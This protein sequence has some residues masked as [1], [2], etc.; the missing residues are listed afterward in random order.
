VE[1]AAVTVTPTVP[2]AAFNAKLPAYCTTILFVPTS[3]REALIVM[4]AE[5]VE[6]VPPRE[7][8]PICWLPAINVTAPVGVTPLE[9][10][11]V[12]VTVTEP[13]DAMDADVD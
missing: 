10:V 9:L 5:V 6:P 3:R 7:A 12:A 4:L 2:E 11:T 8:T 13:V 1:A